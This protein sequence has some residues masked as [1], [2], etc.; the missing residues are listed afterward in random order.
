VPFRLM[1]LSLTMLIVYARFDGGRTLTIATGL[2]V[3]LGFAFHAAAVW[4]YAATANRQLAETREAAATI[5]AGR[6]LY[7]IGTKPDPRFRANPVLHSDAYIALWSRGVLL[8][9]YEAAHYYFPVKLRPNYPQSLVQLTEELQSLD[10][11][12]RSDRVLVED[13]LST[14]KQYIDVLIV[15]TL[16]PGLVSL[17]Q[18]SFSEVLWRSDDLCVLTHKHTAKDAQPGR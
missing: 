12:R 5:P 6:R 7:Q 11:K 10:L 13:F 8:S 2:L 16:D 15:R 9:N 1:L 4:D 18:R 17:A 14:Q 3:T